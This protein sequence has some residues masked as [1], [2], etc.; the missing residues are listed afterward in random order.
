MAATGSTD[1][2]S[3]NGLPD[4]PLLGSDF[5][6]SRPS[7]GE[8]VRRSSGYQLAEELRDL[9]NR[10]KSFFSVLF[11]HDTGGL[12]PNVV[13]SSALVSLSPNPS[14]TYRKFEVNSKGLFVGGTEARDSVYPREFRAVFYGDE[15]I[16]SYVDNEDG[17]EVVVGQSK[18]Y[19]G[20]SF[21]FYVGAT[22]RFYFIE[23]L[24]TVPTGVTRVALS[25]SGSSPLYGPS[26]P[27]I[28]RKTSLR[29]SGGDV[30]KVQVGKDAMTPCRVSK[31]DGSVY[32]DNTDV[33]HGMTTVSQPLSDQIIKGYGGASG[34]PAVVI[35]EWYA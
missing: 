15:S 12:K 5:N 14:G 17:K 2:C 16:E 6:P 19:E 28:T 20:G 26:A 22:N 31:L 18:D 7:D 30:L 11:Y 24:F 23:Y 32:C 10:V 34:D 1:L 3:S 4:M 35:V 21:G 29:V 33:A 8:H 13:P 27:H 9:R 25:L